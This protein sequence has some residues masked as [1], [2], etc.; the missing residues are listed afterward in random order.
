MSAELTDADLQAIRERAEK[1]LAWKP[2]TPPPGRWINVEVVPAL[3]DHIEILRAR[4]DK[5]R[6]LHRKS[7]VYDTFADDCEH[8]SD[9][10]A[11]ECEDGE[12]YC[13]EHVAGYTC[14]ECCRLSYDSMDGE[15]PAY[16]CPTIQALDGS[17]Q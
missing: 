12:F 10:Y 13:T 4:L 9:L 3:L 14:S 2:G 15:L 7:P 1:E 11:T 17:D 6:A 16:P 8:D 5:V